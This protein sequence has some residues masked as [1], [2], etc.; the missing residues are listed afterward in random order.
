VQLCDGTYSVLDSG[1]LVIHPDDP[2]RPVTRMS[3]MFW[4][5]IDELHVGEPRVERTASGIRIVSTLLSEYAEADAKPQ[6][7]PS[8][9][10]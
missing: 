2:F 3:R 7:L 8:D 5:Q 9:D 10:S 6:P 1:V 4:R